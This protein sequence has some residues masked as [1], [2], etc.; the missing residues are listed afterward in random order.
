MVHVVPAVV[1]VVVLAPGGVVGVAGAAP[2]TLVEVHGL[3]VEEGGA[4]EDGGAGVGVLLRVALYRGRAA[5]LGAP[6]EGVVVWL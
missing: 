4:V 6:Q 3:G 1:G 2:R 5:L